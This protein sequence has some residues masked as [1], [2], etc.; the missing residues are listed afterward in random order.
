MF[1]ILYLTIILQ[2]GGSGGAEHTCKC[3]KPTTEQVA[4]NPCPLPTGECL[5]LME[6]AK[7][8]ANFSNDT[9]FFFLP[10]NHSLDG[11]RIFIHHVNNLT[12]SGVQ[13]YG[14]SGQP[15]VQCSG[16]TS[17]FW[18]EDIVDLQIDCLG[19]NNCGF[20]Y[21]HT[22]SQAL[23]M[24]YVTNL[25]LYNVLIKN[26]SGYGLYTVN[27]IGTSVL[28]NV[29]IRESHNYTGCLGGNMLMIHNVER[30]CL[31]LSLLITD[32]FLMNGSI[33][34]YATCSVHEGYASGLGIFLATTNRISVTL[35]NVTLS[36][37]T[38]RNGGNLAI[39]YVHLNTTTIWTSSVTLDNCTISSGLA[40]LGGGMY[41]SMVA[42]QNKTTN[43]TTHRTFNVLTIN[44]T[45]FEH[46]TGLFVGGGLYMKLYEELALS[47]GA[48][49]NI[50]NS[51]FRYN[52][53]QQFTR[54]GGGVAINILNFGLP[55]YK[56][57]Q[58]PQYSVSLISCHF[59]DNKIEAPL[60]ESP[61]G[62]GVLYF[63]Q[64]PLT[65]LRDNKIINNIASGVVLIRSN[66][67]L[68]GT[69]TIFGNSGIRGGGMM[70]CDNS[71]LYLNVNASLDISNNTAL[72]YG[73]GLYVESECAQA[74]PP[75]FFQCENATDNI[76]DVEVYLEN[77][78]AVKAGNA[79]YGGSIEYCYLFGH[80]N[81][82]N[83]TKVFFDIFT[84]SPPGTTDTSSITSDP[85]RV[86]FCSF[87]SSDK[88]L[89][90]NCRGSGTDSQRE[91]YP[92]STFKVP[93]VIVGQR[94]GT[95]PGF[96]IASS[97]S[98]ESSFQSIPNNTCTTLTYSLSPELMCNEN[99]SINISFS[100]QG[101]D[102][103][104]KYNT[105]LNLSVTLKPC[106]LG[107]G[108]DPKSSQCGCVCH[109]A[110]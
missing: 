59:Y 27:M 6:Y 34:G 28:R 69:N 97:V 82:A 52:S 31:S 13:A 1:F 35:R 79:L 25:Y 40:L 29:V 54:D 81:P 66:L 55:G 95:V 94:Y 61:I 99:K 7:F 65:K 45:I 21:Y 36:G 47:T 51:V 16:A 80:Y 46:N 78:S 87:N 77:N 90:R 72:T 76:R 84:I 48:Q 24:R 70:L 15:V 3:V 11:V 106:P 10:G 42:R 12:L 26:S 108:K 83:T 101:R 2:Y 63:E 107:F 60:E 30:E 33:R 41:L 56:H 20:Q 86:C 4:F 67:V 71:I 18:F 88:R 8:P 64:S 85:Q 98:N 9:T 91:L 14:H 96:V 73:G 105:S 102:S 44:H 58:M 74:I 22:H 110:L 50:N 104:K 57:H 75:C 39:S 109:P 5:P 38:A 62:I 68:E 43:T 89:T 93:L 19:F 100:V 49:I 92:G 53:I 103:R 17:G 37:N 32:S 23:L